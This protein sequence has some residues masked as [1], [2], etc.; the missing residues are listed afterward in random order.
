MAASHYEGQRSGESGS[1]GGTC[2][3][4]GRSPTMTDASTRHSDRQR[5]PVRRTCRVCVSHLNNSQPS[6]L[7]LCVDALQK[8]GGTDAHEIDKVGVLNRVGRNEVSAKISAF[9]SPGRWVERVRRC[10][11]MGRA[12]RGEKHDGGIPR[13]SQP[14][15]TG[16]DG[17]I[18]VG[19]PSS[20]PSKKRFHRQSF[21]ERSEC[22]GGGRNLNC[23]DHSVHRDT[24]SRPAKIQGR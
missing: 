20:P 4:R 7:V 22:P 18:S 1:R 23:N 6:Q 16:C 10:G 24:G 12:R 2:E 5:S 15:L 11:A 14:R 21:F 9:L 3:A 17:C 19:D 13:P 8:I